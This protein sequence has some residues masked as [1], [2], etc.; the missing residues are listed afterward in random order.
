MLSHSPAIQGAKVVNAQGEGFFGVPLTLRT[1][2][3]QIEDRHQHNLKSGATDF[4]RV[5]N[6]SQWSARIGCCGLGA[7][8]QNEAKYQTLPPVHRMPS[9]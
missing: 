1:I 5:R 8:R 3:G 4:A 6:Q 7:G 2:Q 9:L